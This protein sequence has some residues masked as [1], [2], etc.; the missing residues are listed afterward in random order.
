MNKYLNEEPMKEGIC[1][2]CGKAIKQR[3]VYA[4]KLRV[5]RI[6]IHKDTKKQDCEKK[7]EQISKSPYLSMPIGHK[8]TCKC[9]ECEIIRRDN[10]EICKIRSKS[11]DFSGN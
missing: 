4:G 9:G 3:R 2:S 7:E 5:Y 11:G 1:E 8:D 6:W 10:I